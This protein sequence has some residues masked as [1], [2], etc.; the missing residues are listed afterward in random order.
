[1]KTSSG[2]ICDHP[3]EGLLV[4]DSERDMHLF[5]RIGELLGRGDIPEE[6]ANVLRKKGG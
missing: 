1:M 5:H 4:D 6:V 2:R 3:G